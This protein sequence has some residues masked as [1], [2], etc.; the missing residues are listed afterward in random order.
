M[1]EAGQRGNLLCR[2]I[3]ESRSDLVYF[4]SADHRVVY[5]NPTLIERTGRNVTEEICYKALHGR[6]SACP[7]CASR[8]IRSGKSYCR[9]LAGPGKGRI[10]YVSNVPG[11]R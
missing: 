2:K 11:Y 6:E 4:C 5:M 7:V 10:Y 9:E 3:V 1:G 8:I